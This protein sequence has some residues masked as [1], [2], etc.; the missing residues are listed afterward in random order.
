M[1]CVSALWHSTGVRTCVLCLN[2]M[3]SHCLYAC[4]SCGIHDLSGYLFG[5]RGRL[6]TSQA[7]RPIENDKASHP[8]QNESSLSTSITGRNSCIYL[9]VLGTQVYIIRVH[10]ASIIGKKLGAKNGNNSIVQAAELNPCKGAGDATMNEKHP[11]NIHNFS[12]GG[13]WVHVGRRKTHTHLRVA[14]KAT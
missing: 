2:A 1:P 10:L 11:C 6:R 12:F 8:I 9:A 14:H 13:G 4:P 7:T 5:A 3:T